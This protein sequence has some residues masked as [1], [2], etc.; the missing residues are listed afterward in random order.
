MRDV[1]VRN[2]IL[3]DGGEVRVVE[4]EEDEHGQLYG[5]ETKEEGGSPKQH[6]SLEGQLWHHHQRSC[7]GIVAL[8]NKGL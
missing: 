3:E 2:S 7:D 4:L 8:V 5:H 6:V 1:T